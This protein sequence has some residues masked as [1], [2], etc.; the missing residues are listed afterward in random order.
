VSN[1]ILIDTSVFIDHLRTGCHQKRIDSL[2]GLVRLSSVVLAELWRGATKPTEQ[3]FLK[4]LE[5]HHPIL[6]PTE[7]IWL[8]SGRLLGKIRR[9]MG[10]SSD[11]LR[12]L[13]FDI[14][15]ALTTR[16]YGAQLITSNGNDFELIRKYRR[17]DLV[18][19]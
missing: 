3:A 17:F 14:L 4:N 7:G 11:K 15:I 16:T 6:T 2:V 9:D 5:K 8:E 1:L 12:D 10:F 19:W 18:I 13:H